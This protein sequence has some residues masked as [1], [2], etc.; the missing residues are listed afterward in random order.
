MMPRPHSARSMTHVRRTSGM[1]SH[2]SWI[3]TTT[4]ALG[5]W[6]SAMPCVKPTCSRRTSSSG[7]ETPGSSCAAP[8]SRLTA[9][10]RPGP[11]TGL[12]AKYLARRLGTAAST[13]IV[14]YCMKPSTRSQIGHA[15]SRPGSSRPAQNVWMNHARSQRGGSFLRTASSVAQAR[16][17]S[18]SIDSRCE[19]RSRQPMDEPDSASSSYTSRGIFAAYAAQRDTTTMRTPISWQRR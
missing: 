2:R 14:S 11:F 17:H 15:P 10:W 6:L 7:C 18:T 1:L 16:R 19:L 12:G 3:I 4:C 9:P 8:I 5:V 13:A